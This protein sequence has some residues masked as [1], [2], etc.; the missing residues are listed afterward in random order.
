MDFDDEELKDAVNDMSICLEGLTIVLS[1]QFESI[2]RPKL[3]EFIRDHGGKCTSAMSG[4]TN[5]LVV[6]YK[7]ED[8]REI[9][10]GSK[11]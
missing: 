11:Y 9:T 4:K 8:G 2:S 3:E 6:G 10:Q 5:Y 1:G 7:L